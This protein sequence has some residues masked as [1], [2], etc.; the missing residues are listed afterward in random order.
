MPCHQPNNIDNSPRI[1]RWGAQLEKHQALL[2]IK[3][4]LFMTALFV[5]SGYALVSYLLD[6]GNPQHIQAIP[7]IQM[8]NAG[9]IFITLYFGVVEYLFRNRPK[10]IRLIQRFIWYLA[11]LFLVTATG[12]CAM[13]FSR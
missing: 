9:L 5:L 12:F 6:R 13:M 3:S 10:E 11:I 4:L 7:V 1:K 8:G 2:T